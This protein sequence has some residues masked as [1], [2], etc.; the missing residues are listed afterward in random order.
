MDELVRVATAS[1]ASS[2]ASCVALQKLPEGD[3]NNVFLLTLDDGRQ[4]VA[5]VPNP[6]TEPPFYKTAS[7]VATMDFVQNIVRIPMPKVVAWNSCLANAVGAEYIIM[8]K[9]DG[10]LLSSEWATM[11]TAQKHQLIQTIIAFERAFLSHPFAHIGSL[12]S[13]RPHAVGQFSPTRYPG[14]VVGPTTDRRFWGDGRKDIQSDKGPWASTLD[15]PDN[16]S[17]VLSIIG[18]QSVHIAPLFQQAATPAFLDF[19][20]PKPDEGVSAPSLPENFEVLSAA[21]QAQAKT[22]R[23]QQSLYKLY[24]IQSARQNKKVFKALQYTGSLGSQIISLVF[25]VFNDGEPII[26]GQLIQLAQEW[27]RIVGN[28]RQTCPLSVTPD[29]IREREHDLQKWEEGVQLMEDVLDS[30]GGVENGWQGWVSYEDYDQMRDKLWESGREGSLVQ[31]M[32]FSR[33]EL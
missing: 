18:W 26:R 5:K 3:S 22:L 10:V 31:G 25:Q 20:G 8:E 2:P 4:L 15:H 29:D 13:E 11:S 21:E 30:L 9:A 23:T 27:D 17:K 19:E 32:A 12:Y 24:E 1:I 14:F 28:D 33:L 16:P 6:N 7:E